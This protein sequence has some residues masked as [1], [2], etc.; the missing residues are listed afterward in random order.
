MDILST[1]F[2]L[3]LAAEVILSPVPQGPSSPSGGEAPRT[4]PMNILSV[5]DQISLPLVPDVSPT[6]TPTPS[7][8][9]TPQVKPLLRSHLRIA[10]LGDSMTDTLGPDVPHLKDELHKLYPNL[11]TTILNYGVG[12]TNI[13][14]GIERITTD[15]EYLGK[16]I[17]A[18][19]K[20][21]PDI[22]VIESFAYNPFPDADSGINR[23]WLALG[24]AVQ[25]IKTVLPQ[26]KI[27]IATTVAPDGNT[28][29]KGAPGI[30]YTEGSQWEHVRIIQA[31][32]EST[33]AFAKSERLVLANAYTPSLLSNGNGNPLY[34]NKGDNIHPSDQGK[35]LFAYVLVEAMTKNGLLE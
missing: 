28:F 32:L 8:L 11:Q 33:I 26:A 19:V 13:E 16:K 12:A 10:L 2:G 22:V 14:Y 9:P 24:K 30:E 23:H 17:P 25:T 20:E 15:Y 31:Y 29:A 3:V 1:V 18:M 5:T 34:I 4:V 27:I 7:T 6:Q 21:N 35:S